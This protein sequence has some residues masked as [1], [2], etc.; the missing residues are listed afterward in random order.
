VG[1]DAHKHLR[2][3]LSAADR[4]DLVKSIGPGLRE[5]GLF[6]ATDALLPLG[7]RVQLELQFRDGRPAL[8]GPGVVRGV[9]PGPGERGMTL[10]VEWE[11]E[12][13]PLLSWVMRRASRPAAEAPAPPTPAPAGAV[14][15]DLPDP[16]RPETEPE[17]IFAALDALMVPGPRPGSAHLE[18]AF[19]APVEQDG[20]PSDDLLEPTGVVSSRTADLAGDDAEPVLLVDIVEEPNP[21][22]EYAF[23][24]TAQDRLGPAPAPTDALSAVEVAPRPL[25][26]APLQ[27]RLPGE[28]TPLARI[29]LVRRGAS[30]VRPGALL[31]PPPAAVE[32]VPPTAIPSKRDRPAPPPPSRRAV[33]IDPGDQTT[34]VA[35]VEAGRARVLPSRGGAPGVPSAVFIEPGGRT[36]VGEPAA[37]RLSWQPELGILGTRRLIGRFF[38][39][40]RVESV[41]ARLHCRIGA[42]EEDEVALNIGAHFI[43]LEE[44]QA[45]VLKEARASADLS[46][47]DSV[48]RVVLTCPASYG[49]RQRMALKVAG[50]LAGLH[51]ERVLSS[52]LAVVLAELKE[53]RLGAGLYLVY[54]FG[55]GSF[56]CAVVKVTAHSA[57]ILAAGGDPELGGV[58]LDHALAER[59][60]EEVEHASGD[61]PTRP[62][63]SDMM[64]AVEV[65]KCALSTDSATRIQVDGGEGGIGLEVEVL[66]AEAEALFAPFVER[67]FEVVKAVLQQAGL[68]RDALDGVLLMGGQ[69]RVPLVRR[70]AEQLLGDRLWPVDPI[71]AQVLG[72]AW[73]AAELESTAPF[74]LYELLPEPIAVGQ[75]DGRTRTVLEAGAVLPTVACFEHVATGPHELALFLFQGGCGHVERDEPLAHLRLPT[76]LESQDS[77]DLTP[78]AVEYPWCVEVTVS[79]GPDGTLAF[80]ATERESGQAVPVEEVKECSREL[81]RSHFGRVPGMASP[82]PPHGLFGRLLRAFRLRSTSAS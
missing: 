52:P 75:P 5:D 43:S 28:V 66:R 82:T 56:D 57:Q 7:T 60:L 2:V 67:S 29:E 48:N 21:S 22:T 77:A 39:S 50:A 23:S 40:P 44:I 45:L 76:R 6:L 12:A 33:G 31:R 13:I 26:S 70:R 36:I 10:D 81:L 20:T 11:I 32:L 55:A 46:L 51:V 64:D 78:R 9:V 30:D 18:I 61:L 4:D 37:R 59:V 8:W 54:D 71:H 42:A 68:T 3:R 80:S 69:A 15:H 14:M 38:C 74:A 27:D 19:E 34:R 65:G 73:A 53:G 35:V 79:V 1:S 47:R 62:G 24:R 72:A 17:D 41:K 58:E 25:L 63:L 16:A 49:A